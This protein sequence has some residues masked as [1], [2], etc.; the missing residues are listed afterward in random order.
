MLVVEFSEHADQKLRIL[1]RHG[2]KVTPKLVE[3]VVSKPDRV[4][5]GA[6][7]RQIAE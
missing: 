6:G 7:G 2:V 1:R 4:V 3:D 5:Q